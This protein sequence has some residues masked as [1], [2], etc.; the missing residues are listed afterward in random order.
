MKKG[1][2]DGVGVAALEREH[3]GVLKKQEH[4]EDRNLVAVAVFLREWLANDP[5]GPD[6]ENGAER[7]VEA[8]RPDVHRRLQREPAHPEEKMEEEGRVIERPGP[9]VAALP[10]VDEIWRCP[11]GAAHVG[12]DVLQVRAPRLHERK[13]GQRRQGGD[14]EDD[15]KEELRAAV[16]RKQVH[17]L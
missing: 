3:E 10:A 6:V 11:V 13:V 7:E 9:E 14:Q 4:A 16:Q 15:Q 2:R 12:V 5:A 17:R 1:D 8:H